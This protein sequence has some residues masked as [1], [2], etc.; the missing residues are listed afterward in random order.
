MVF[1][2]CKRRN[3]ELAASLIGEIAAA[4]MLDLMFDVGGGEDY[5]GINSAK[6]LISF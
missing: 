6:F 5:H 1:C 2:F 4:G 3:T